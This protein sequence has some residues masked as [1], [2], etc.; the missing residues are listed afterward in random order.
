LS[1]LLR[2]FDAVFTGLKNPWGIMKVIEI[3][4]RFQKGEEN[5]AKSRLMPPVPVGEK[6]V[7]LFFSLPKEYRDQLSQVSLI[8]KTPRSQL[9]E[10][11]LETY[12]E[13]FA[14]EAL[15]Q[16]VASR[17]RQ[18]QETPPPEPPVSKGVRDHRPCRSSG[19]I[20]VS[21]VLLVSQRWWKVLAKTICSLE[22]VL[23]VSSLS[24]V[25]TLFF[26]YGWASF[27]HRCRQGLGGV[28]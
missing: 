12:W 5:M 28:G 27:E 26:D 13:S 21:V 25:M 4:L 15:P 16:A 17:Q 19:C 18:G 14:R 7:L 22:K 20:R 11:F 8:L 6:R 10:D 23:Y 9:L 1:T 2:L 3:S 24:E